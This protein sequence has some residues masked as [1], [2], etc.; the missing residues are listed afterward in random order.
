[1]SNTAR[2]K[3]TGV[4]KTEER[5]RDHVWTTTL[6]NGKR[7]ICKVVSPDRFQTEV[8]TLGYLRDRGCSVP[9]LLDSD[10]ERGI[11][12]TEWCGDQ[13]V[14]DVCQSGDAQRRHLVGRRL[15]EAFCEIE[16][17]LTQPCEDLVGRAVDRDL[18]E[19]GRHTLMRGR[20]ALLGLIHLAGGY[21]EEADTQQLGRLWQELGEVILTGPVTFGSCDYNALNV[22][23][24]ERDEVTF[25]DF[26]LL[27]E[28]WP[29]RRLVQYA[30]GLGTYCEDGNIIGL[31]DEGVAERYAEMMGDN[32]AMVLK[33]LD[34]HSLLFH[35]M[36]IAN[37]VEMITA[38]EQ[39]RSK[40]L[41]EAWGE[42]RA[43]I[44]QVV[45]GVLT[46]LS[47][48]ETMMQLRN[49]LKDVLWSER[50]RLY[51]NL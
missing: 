31:L 7:A 13:T 35:V 41:R 43:R 50:R 28:D 29:E 33:R 42:P 10:E 27:G 5:I 8:T 3:T 40:L 48:D 38:P 9:L 49:L 1:M 15:V 18:R 14:D 26:S 37:L 24:D 19:E 17:A 16:R 44:G 45:Q 4:T 46:P 2:R 47:R 30:T 32:P 23:V 11:I 39:Q 34:A 20:L 22:V 6:T 51:A 12:I 36:I 21:L 25:I